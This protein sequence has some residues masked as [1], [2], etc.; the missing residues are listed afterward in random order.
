MN[1]RRLPVIRPGGRLPRHRM[2]LAIGGLAVL[3]AALLLGFWSGSQRGSAATGSLVLCADRQGKVT[4]RAACRTAERALSIAPASVQSVE[5]PPRPV[6]VTAALRPNPSV[7]TPQPVVTETVTLL[8]EAPR[9]ITRRLRFS[10][11]SPI[12]GEVTSSLDPDDPYDRWN[13]NAV[14]PN[15]PRDLPV[16]VARSIALLPYP[17]AEYRSVPVE[18][19]R[20]WQLVNM[21]GS[22]AV[23]V[24]L[25]DDLLHSVVRTFD[26]S[27]DGL[28]TLWF[29]LDVYASVTCLPVTGLT[30]SS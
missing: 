15:C 27:D 4:V 5:L 11:G 24:T 17:T 3:L 7:H 20:H 12:D 16:V 18:A 9:T 6:T 10:A 23:N 13:Q 2:L 30:P 19:G 29:D 25:N 14:L 28:D 1:L 26:G 8:A 22:D 21:E